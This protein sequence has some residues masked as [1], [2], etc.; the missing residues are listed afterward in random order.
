MLGEK[1]LIKLWDSIA[2]KGIGGLLTPWQ[3]LRESDARIEARRRETLLLADAE[4][5]AEEIRQGKVQLIVDKSN[6]EVM[7]S[8]YIEL[9][10]DVKRNEPKFDI[11]HILK[12]A[13]AR[14]KLESIREEINISKAIIHAEEELVGDPQS[15]PD[16]PIDEDWLYKWKENA[17]KV[18]TEELQQLWGKILA[19]EVKSPGKYSLRTMDFLKNISQEEARLIEQLAQFNI[20]GC[21][22]RDEKDILNNNGI[23]FG[24]LLFLQ[25]LGVIIGVEAIGMSMT[26]KSNVAE[27]FQKVLVSNKKALLILHEDNSKKLSLNSYGLSSLGKQIVSLGN[28]E[29]NQEYLTS[30]G[31]KIVAQGFEVQLGDWISV[32]ENHGQMSNSVEF[33]Q[34]NA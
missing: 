33:N 22:A 12:H 27:S 23:T 10:D 1:L 18:S 16:R 21:I 26:Y 19:G 31:K 3:I 4:K 34:E 9:L 28:F 30:I 2:D 6:I 8:G 29:S 11:K 15:A 13:D 25:E 20:S 5:T 14:E 7:P 17:S 32:D 24:K